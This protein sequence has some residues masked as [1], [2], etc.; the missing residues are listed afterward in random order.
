M[1]SLLNLILLL[2]SP[3]KGTTPPKKLPDAEYVD[4]QIIPTLTVTQVHYKDFSHD[5]NI[6]TK[7]SNIAIVVTQIGSNPL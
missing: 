2:G 5:E 3:I 4:V 1:I 6:S 7:I